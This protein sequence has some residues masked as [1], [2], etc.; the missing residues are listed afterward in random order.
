MPTITRK[1][2][3]SIATGSDPRKLDQQDTFGIV[4][5]MNETP[6]LRITGLTKRYGDKIAVNNISLEVP[7]GQFF[8]YLGP[9]GAGKSTTIHC[10]T[11]ISTFS[12]GSITVYG[13]DVQD[14]YRDARRQIGL[15]PQE[16]NVDIFA[17]VW[18]ILDYM[19][20]YYG[21]EAPQRA[22]RIDELIKRFELTAHRDKPFQALSGGLKRRVILARAL[23]HN[24]SMLI[25]DEPT[26][27][28]DVELRRDLWRY[29]RELNEEGKTIIFTSHYLEEVQ[30]LCERV[31]MIA[32][33]RIVA[34]DSVK[35]FTKGGKH[36]LED[37]YLE[38]TRGKYD[39]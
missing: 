11:G 14:N 31:A 6:A 12:E 20:G 2:G 19:G 18:K 15:S 27:G 21:L 26:A 39:K 37:I 8:G 5:R 17:P 9:N 3:R 32:Q 35:N 29:F 16:F 36:K 23:I 24:P 13:H 22:K 34:D 30:E 28:V 33:G 7:K 4:P 38:Y 25:L 10:I 1:A